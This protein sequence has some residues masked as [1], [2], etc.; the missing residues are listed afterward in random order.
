MTDNFSMNH[1][2]KNFSFFFYY[3]QNLYSNLPFP[4]LKISL[5]TVPDLT[6]LSNAIINQI[7]SF[8]FDNHFMNCQCPFCIKCVDQLQLDC[9]KQ[10]LLD[11]IFKIDCC[12][13][14]EN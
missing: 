6:T 13:N 14:F 11:L 8:V 5:Q 2:I 10:S 4:K 7:M 3:F 1:L 9:W 12:N